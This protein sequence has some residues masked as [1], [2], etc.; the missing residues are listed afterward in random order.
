MDA[1]VL[2]PGKVLRLEDDIPTIDHRA[3]AEDGLDRLDVIADAGGAPHVVGGILV[4]R[5]VSRQPRGYHRPGIGEVR[6]FRLVELLKHAG[7]DLALQKIRRRHH[8]VVA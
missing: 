4:V 6:Q 5:V 7:F 2:E 1:A 3:G 8:H